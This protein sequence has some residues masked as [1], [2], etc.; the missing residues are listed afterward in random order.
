MYYSNSKIRTIL[1]LH[2]AGS[3]ILILLSVTLFRD[4]KALTK[5]V[6][7]QEKT[8]TTKVEIYGNDAY[9]SFREQMEDRISVMHNDAIY[10]LK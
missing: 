4:I 8:V 6:E 9:K 5:R 7:T 1:W 10:P 3:V 2:T